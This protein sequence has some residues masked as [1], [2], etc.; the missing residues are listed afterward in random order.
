[1]SPARFTVRLTVARL[2]E[3][4]LEARDEQAARDIADYLYRVHGP[5]ALC[6]V[7][8]DVVDTTVEREED[9]A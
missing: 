7:M 4:E 9:A 5:R 3:L 8:D 1:M 2:Y 6:H